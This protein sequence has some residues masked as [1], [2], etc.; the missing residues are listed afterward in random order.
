MGDNS[1][2]SNVDMLSDSQ[3]I[4]GHYTDIP[5]DNT[6]EKPLEPHSNVIN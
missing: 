4:V 1:L 3:N 2:E 5:N 6:Y